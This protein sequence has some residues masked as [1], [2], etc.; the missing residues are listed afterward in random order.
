M[1]IDCQA[2]AVRFLPCGFQQILFI[3]QCGRELRT[4]SAFHI[5]PPRECDGMDPEESFCNWANQNVLGSCPAHFPQ[6]R[7]FLVAE[8]WPV[9]K[10]QQAGDCCFS[11]SVNHGLRLVNV[12]GRV[13]GDE[14]WWKN[15]TVGLAVC[16]KCLWFD[17]FDCH[18]PDR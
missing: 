15:V 4:A 3:Q 10:M 9:E 14:R 13:K 8:K 2:R 11:T 6:E 7:I 1:F 5:S 18:G 12:V 17:G 16:N